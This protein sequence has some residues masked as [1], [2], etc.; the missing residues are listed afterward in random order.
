LFAFYSFLRFNTSIHQSDAELTVSYR[1]LRRR[2]EHSGELL[3]APSIDLVGPVI[4]L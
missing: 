2:V 4:R 1:S 3:D